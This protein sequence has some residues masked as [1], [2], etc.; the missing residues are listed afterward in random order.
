MKRFFPFVILIFLAGCISKPDYENPDGYDFSQPERILMKESLLEISGITFHHGMPDTILAI[1]DESGK[2]FFLTE[3]NT[4]PR[5]VKFAGQGDYEDIAV[6]QNTIYILR[7]DGSLF[8]LPDSLTDEKVAAAKWK[9]V[10]PK[11]EYE[12]LYINNTTHQLYVLCKQCGK[13]AKKSELQ[14][15]RINLADSNSSITSFNVNIPKEQDK[16]RFL[17]SAMAQHPVTGDW[18]I[19]SSGNKQFLIADSSWNVKRVFSIDP[20]I[21]IQPEGMVFDKNNNLY[22]S[23]EG[24]DLHNGNIL[25]FIYLNQNATN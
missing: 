19:A 20:G 1:N 24:N 18:F 16:K 5:A 4:K 21:F 25:K 10:F 14:G 9:K 23:N 17:P 2:L 8:T 11:G 13:K 15:Y 12:S 6:H 22:I 7:S 3:A